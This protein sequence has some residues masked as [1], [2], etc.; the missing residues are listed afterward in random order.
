MRRRPRLSRL[1]T[2]SN[3]SSIPSRFRD[4]A[5]TNLTNSRRGSAQRM[6]RKSWKKTGKSSAAGF[7]TAPPEHDNN[8]SWLMTLHEILE[9]VRRVEIRTNRLVNDMMVGAYLSHFKGRG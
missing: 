8:N 6:G 1:T 5:D 9:T 2:L 4:F 3:G 7:C